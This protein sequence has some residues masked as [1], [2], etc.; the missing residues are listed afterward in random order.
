MNEALFFLHI[1]IV[2]GFGFA[3]LRLG[4]AV[5]TAWIV[6]QA[7]MANLFVIKQVCFLGFHV[8][9]GDVFAIGSIFGINLLREYYPKEKA[10]QA[11]WACFFAMLFFVVMA[12]VHLLYRPSS[13]DTTHS[14]FETILSASPRLLLASLAV[15][16]VTQ[17]I[18]LRLFTYLKR[19]FSSS[20]LTLRNGIS[21]VM[22][23]FLD[24]TLFSFLG[25]WGI[26]SH[27][28][29][30]ILVSFLIKLVVIALMSPLIHFS[31]RFL[32]KEAYGSV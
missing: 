3:A 18:D 6:L 20:P 22:A 29:D 23:Q 31:R 21:V 4:P 32:P 17:Q 2:L 26:V 11:L 25:L 13:F 14:A 30:I 1:L 24:T 5:L 15:F 7:I 12:K 10:K 19:R 27:L 28:F 16:F 9:C 8:T